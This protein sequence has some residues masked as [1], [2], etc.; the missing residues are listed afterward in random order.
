MHRT[1]AIIILISPPVKSPSSGFFFGDGVVDI[2]TLG[3]FS[4]MFLSMD[5]GRVLIKGGL[6]CSAEKEQVV[7]GW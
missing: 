2:A 1:L 6:L 7:K 5:G 3:N 4:Q